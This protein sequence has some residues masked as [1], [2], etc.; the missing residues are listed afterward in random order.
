MNIGTTQLAIQDEFILDIHS[1][2][3]MVIISE[4]MIEFINRLNISAEEKLSLGE[5][6]VEILIET[7]LGIKSGEYTH[8]DKERDRETLNAFMS[9]LTAKKIK[10]INNERIKDTLNKIQN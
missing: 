7:A 8:K 6:G 10:E 4:V 9:N 5:I 3:V 1:D 2:T